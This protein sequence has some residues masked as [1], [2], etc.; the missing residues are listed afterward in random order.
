MCQFL[1]CVSIVVVPDAHEFLDRH[2]GVLLE[3]VVQAFFRR[4]GV[5]RGSARRK[6]V[7]Q[8]L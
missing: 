5:V 3:V 8:V 4:F 7:R 2:H 6:R 1:G